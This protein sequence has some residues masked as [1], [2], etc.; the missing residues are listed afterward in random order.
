MWDLNIFLIIY[1]HYSNESGFCLYF[2]GILLKRSGK[3]LNKE[4]KKKYV[5]LCDNGVLTYHPSLHVSANPNHVHLY[6]ELYS[7]T[8]NNFRKAFLVCDFGF[9]WKFDQNAVM[10]DG[11]SVFSFIPEVSSELVIRDQP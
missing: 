7:R 11:R 6:A 1:H 2:Q 3:S 4:W 10:S 5:T 9:C 8:Y